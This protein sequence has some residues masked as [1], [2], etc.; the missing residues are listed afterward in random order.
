MLKPK[1]IMVGSSFRSVRRAFSHVTSS[2][3]NHHQC[4]INLHW[5]DVQLSI[6]KLKISITVFVQRI[7][8]FIELSFLGHSLS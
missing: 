6:A 7:I 5:P 4:P 2:C 8:W 1:N 3:V